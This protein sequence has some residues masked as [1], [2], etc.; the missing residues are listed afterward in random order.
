[1][2]AGEGIEVAHQA[3]PANVGRRALCR[4]GDVIRREAHEP[5][6]EDLVRRV[7]IPVGALCAIR[8]RPLK[9]IVSSHS[10]PDVSGR[11]ARL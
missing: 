3:V 9:V 10:E 1:M 5:R 4:L 6:E 11:V 7:I 2:K 8:V